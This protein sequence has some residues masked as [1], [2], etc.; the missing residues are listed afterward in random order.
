MSVVKFDNKGNPTPPG[1]KEIEISTLKDTYVD[2][3]KKSNTRLKIF[4]SYIKFNFD[5]KTLINNQNFKQYLNGSFTTTKVNPADID[6]VN[7]INVVN[8]DIKIQENLN[9]YSTQGGCK[10]NY[11]VDSYLVPV[12]PIDDVR[13]SITKYWLEYWENFFGKDR[14]GDR[15]TLF[16]VNL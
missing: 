11:L 8:L 16:T 2:N 1:L 5:L 7:L 10:N 14:D 13:Y 15:K 9:S 3:F 6:I 4:N 12:Y